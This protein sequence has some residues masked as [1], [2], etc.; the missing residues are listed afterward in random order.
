MSADIYPT[1]GETQEWLNEIW[2]SDP[3]LY[4]FL[5]DADF[6]ADPSMLDSDVLEERM[7]LMEEEQI[8]LKGQKGRGRGF[9]SL[10]KKRRKELARQG[11]KAAHKGGKAHEWDSEEARAARQKAIQQMRE[12]KNKDV[13]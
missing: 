8:M 6:E 10:E 1:P 5:V 12:Q 2:S 3:D 9:A 7:C 4:Y 11:G 13:S